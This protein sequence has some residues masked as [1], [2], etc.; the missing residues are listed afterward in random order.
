[1]AKICLFNMPSPWLINDRVLPPLGILY[2]A[3]Y[4]RLKGHEVIIEDLS[5]E[6]YDIY[7]NDDCIAIPKADFY[8]ISFTTPQVEYA[9]KVLERIVDVYHDAIVIAGGIHATSLPQETLDMGFDY[10]VRGDG[11]LAIDKIIEGKQ[12]EMITE[13]GYIDNLN[14]LPLPSWDLID[15][16]SYI[17]NIDVMDY[18][19]SGKK[20]EREI[21][22]MATRGCVGK[23]SYCNIYKGKYR[24]RSVE[25][26]ILEIQELIKLYKINR[27]SFCDDNLT[28]DTEWLLKLCAELKKLDI[29]W[30]CLGRVDSA[31]PK[32]YEIMKESGCMGIDFGIETGSRK[33]LEII[34]KGV[35]L[36]QQHFG[37][38]WAKEAGLKVRAQL[39]IGLPQETDETINETIEFIKRN[40]E[41]VDKW[42]LHTFVPFPSCDI[43]NKPSKYEYTIKNDFSTFQTIGKKGQW[44]YEPID[45]KNKIKTWREDVLK[46]IGERTIQ[47]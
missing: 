9:R 22:I 19:S 32:I 7:E 36:E 16:E 24:T 2:L 8:G 20:Q 21:S 15:L 3:S 13:F 41:Y 30:H 47:K 17:R 40:Y 45:F 25:N 18:M 34:N 39:M 11:E 5:G 43:Y 28:V 12:K 26:V 33:M 4:L 14:Y 31:G 1:M 23:C 29:K 27:I 37:L 42:G 44:T 35:S 38:R 10:V 6:M 46:A